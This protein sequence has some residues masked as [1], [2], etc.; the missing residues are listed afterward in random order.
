MRPIFEYLSAKVKPTI[1]KANDDNIRDIVKAELDKLGLEAD[2][3]HID[4]SDVT[5]F[6]S[7]FAAKDRESVL[8][9]TRR[10]GKKYMNINPNV[11][12]WN[13][14]QAKTMH[15]MFIN[16]RMFSCDLS[17]WDVSHVTDMDYMFCECYEFNG[18]ITTWDV[19]SVD[20]MQGMF[21]FAESFNQDISG[22]DISNV[23][24]AVYMFNACKSFNQDL[25][26]WKFA[27]HVAH[28]EIFKSCNKSWPQNK[29]PRC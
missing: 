6:S 7:L 28:K 26:G 24:N 22:W 10:L 20:S 21:S 4:V 9:G 1:I 8:F 27:E 15:E 25:S 12:Q 16:C 17:Q 23:T 11:S 29:R 13:V 3:S 19:S 14:S 5:D 18:D 2:L